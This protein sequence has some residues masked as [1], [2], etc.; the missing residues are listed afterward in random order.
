M[1]ELNCQVQFMS[2]WLKGYGFEELKKVEIRYIPAY[3]RSFDRKI[4]R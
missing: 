4:M 1:I 3:P 2:L